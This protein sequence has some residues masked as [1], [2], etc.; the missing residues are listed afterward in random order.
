MWNK[1][2]EINGQKVNSQITAIKGIDNSIITDS[3]EMANLLATTFAK[4]SSNENFDPNFLKIKDSAEESARIEPIDSLAKNHPLNT[5]ISFAELQS[6]VLILKSA[7]K[8]SPGPDMIPSHT[9]IRGN[10]K[11]DSTAKLASFN[12]TL[13]N[14]EYIDHR[15]FQKYCIKVLMETWNEEWRNSSPTK[16]H[17]VRNNINDSNPA[18][19]FNRKDQVKITRLR[20]GHSNW[21]RSHLI[22]KTE[23]NICDICDIQNTIEHILVTC[24]KYNTK[25]IQHKLPNSLNVLREIDSC[26]KVLDVTL[27][28]QEKKKKKNHW[29]SEIKKLSFHVRRII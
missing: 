1:L 6:R 8:S 13:A 22:T 15:D 20:I 19:Q 4:N 21:T 29:M 18:V 10:E 2:K 23:P 3:I 28:T 12:A 5:E 25:R 17:D 9:G 11:A 27:N 16:L 24:P 14:Y 7:K 26:K